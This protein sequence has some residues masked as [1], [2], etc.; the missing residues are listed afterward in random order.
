VS[1]SPAYHYLRLPPFVRVGRTA[2]LPTLPSF[3]SLYRKKKKKKKKKKNCFAVLAAGRVRMAP[4]RWAGRKDGRFLLPVLTSRGGRFCVNDAVYLHHCTFFSHVMLFSGDGVSLGGRPLL[5]HPGVSSA[6]HNGVCM[7]R[8]V[9]G[10]AGAVLLKRG[11]C[12]GCCSLPYV[13]CPLPF[14]PEP[15]SMTCAT[16]Y[17]TLPSSALVTWARLAG[18]LRHKPLRHGC[19]R[20]PQH[21]RTC[22]AGALCRPGT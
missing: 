7:R 19:W 4:R 5:L 13:L 3:L 14:P 22:T 15:F 21:R 9:H 10:R 1:A 16:F 8:T 6:R 11:G 2:F 20:C 17:P 18:C 12:C